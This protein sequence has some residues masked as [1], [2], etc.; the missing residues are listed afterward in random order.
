VNDGRDSQSSGV[1]QC[2]AAKQQTPWLTAAEAASY[3]KMQV[4]TLLKYTRE[5]KIKGYSLS[6]TKRKVS[7]YLRNDLDAYLLNNVITSGAPSVLIEGE[8]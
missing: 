8:E 2:A 4:R 7:R 3:L 1:P 6:G 5:R